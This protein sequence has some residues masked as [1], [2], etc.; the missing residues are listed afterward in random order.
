[1]CASI[2][3]TNQPTTDRRVVGVDREMELS[4]S[5]HPVWAMYNDAPLVAEDRSSHRIVGYATSATLAGHA[6][7]E[8][9]EVVASI[10]FEMTSNAPVGRNKDAILLKVIGRLSPG[11]VKWALTS[12]GLELQR[13]A[14]LMVLGS[15]TDP[16]AGVYIPSA[17]F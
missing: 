2:H 10:H 11:L 8:S 13:N 15:Y 9:E 17:T 16:T 12:G 1:M 14:T 7:G 5:L 3:P 6:V 4:N